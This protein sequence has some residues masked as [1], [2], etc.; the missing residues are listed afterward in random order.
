MR[1]RKRFTHSAIFSIIAVSCLPELDPSNSCFIIEG[2]MTIEHETD[3]SVQE[4][5][6]EVRAAIKSSMDND[7]LIDVPT[8]EKVTYLGSSISNIA[9]GTTNTVRGIGLPQSPVDAAEEPRADDNGVG[10]SIVMP[11]IAAA[12]IIALYLL[13]QR[14]RHNIQREIHEIVDM[15][16]GGNLSQCDSNADDDLAGAVARV[17]E[18]IGSDG[19]PPGSF[20]MG[21][22]HYTVDGVKYKSKICRACLGLDDVLNGDD[23]FDGER[24][25]RCLPVNGEN[26]NER[27]P[28][29]GNNASSTDVHKCNSSMCAICFNRTK[30][31][32]FVPANEENY[33][34]AST[35]SGSTG[36]DESN[37]RRRYDRR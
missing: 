23:F 37:G 14:R 36:S 28:S 35:S 18:D 17:L 25:P 32:T 20:H 13:L 29:Y 5:T 31:V 11:V 15:D 19:D 12:L 10:L 33:S 2:T 3:D 1:V 22:S 16:G 9:V 7:E 27:I 26:P 30:S 8:V 4:S 21:D 24:T 6:S 34:D